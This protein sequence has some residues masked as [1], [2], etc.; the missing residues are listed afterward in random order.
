[1]CGDFEYGERLLEKALSLCLEID[2]RPTLGAIENAFGALLAIKG[3][4][5]RAVSHLQ[6][7]IKYYEES[8]FIAF[9]GVVWGWLGWAHYQMGQTKTAVELVEKGLSI[10]IDL[11]IPYSRSGLHLYCAGTYFM[12]GDLDRARTQA[13]LALQYAM[14]NNE[15]P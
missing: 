1:M 11:G 15:R 3:D 13:E 12:T 2:H 8:Q 10:H 9:L 14:E 4:G 7:S 6:R 5:E